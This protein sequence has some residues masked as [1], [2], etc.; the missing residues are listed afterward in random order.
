MTKTLNVP[1]HV[2]LAEGLTIANFS[3]TSRLLTG[4]PRRFRVTPEQKAR[5]KAGTLTREGAL[6]ERIA[7]ARNNGGTA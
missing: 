2:F 7:E 5:I 6:A 4:T 1:N 3:E